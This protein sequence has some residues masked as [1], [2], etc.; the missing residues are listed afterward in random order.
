[1]LKALLDYR[2]CLRCQECSAAKVCPSKAIY[3]LEL[4]GPAVIEKEYCYG[5]GDCTEEC[6]AKAVEVREM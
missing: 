6:P 4:E 2:K 1:M 5:C 3:K